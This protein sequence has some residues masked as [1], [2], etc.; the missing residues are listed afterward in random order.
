MLILERVRRA[1][2]AEEQAYVEPRVTVIE[3]ID[4][5]LAA[6]PCQMRFEK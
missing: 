3:Q 5:I 1:L 2:T 6:V 4:L